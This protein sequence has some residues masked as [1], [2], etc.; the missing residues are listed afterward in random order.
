MNRAASLTLLASL[1]C[2]ADLPL[3]VEMRRGPYSVLIDRYSVAALAASQ[4]ATLERGVIDY[5]AKTPLRGEGV[6]IVWTA[7]TGIVAALFTVTVRRGPDTWSVSELC[8]APVHIGGRAQ[9]YIQTGP[10]DVATDLNAYPAALSRTS[11]VFP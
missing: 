4:A 11:V 6:T 10:F 3:R 1:A 9:C 2:A 5:I 7:P 8:P